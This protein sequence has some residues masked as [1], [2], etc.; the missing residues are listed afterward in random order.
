M[1]GL[2]YDLQSTSD[3]SLLICLDF[4]VENKLF[5]AVYS[6]HHA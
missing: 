3:A 1:E 5:P 2:I 6:A 4:K